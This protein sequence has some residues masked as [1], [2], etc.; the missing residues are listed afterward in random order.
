[1]NIHYQSESWILER[2]KI[3][4]KIS[5]YT[6]IIFDDSIQGIEFFDS[7]A[8]SFQKGILKQVGPHELISLFK[9]FKKLI[10]KIQKEMT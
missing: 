1:M 3:P 9:N 5:V 4:S 2:E 10:K 6:F 7:P 8:F